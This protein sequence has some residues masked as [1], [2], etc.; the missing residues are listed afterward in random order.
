MFRSWLVDQ[1]EPHRSVV[2]LHHVAHNRQPEAAMALLSTGVIEPLK[3]LQ[4]AVPLFPRHATA[5]IPDFDVKGL[6]VMTK[7]DHNRCLAI[8]ESVVDQIGD[9]PAQG[10]RSNPGLDRLEIQLELIRWVAG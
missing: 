1:P 2:A 5:L 6:A 4:S 10:H 9:G 3:R 8:G 7:P